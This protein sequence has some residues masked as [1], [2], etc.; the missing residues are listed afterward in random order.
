MVRFATVLVAT[1][2]GAVSAVGIGRDRGTL[3][4]IRAEAAKP[5]E[6]LDPKCNKW[7]RVVSGDTCEGVVKPM[8]IDM[9]DFL[10][11]NTKITKECK[12]LM[13][14]Y[15]VC[16]GVSGTPA[17]SGTNS[18]T[19]KPPASSSAPAIHHQEVHHHW[20]F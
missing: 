6:G 4:A 1:L 19:S 11:W 12:E 5:M 9:D 2:A 14:G 7:H 18:P 20:A 16:I 17:A 3:M 10:K 15:D 13:L 8:G